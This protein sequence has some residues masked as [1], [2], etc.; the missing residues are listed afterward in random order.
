MRSYKE[1]ERSPNGVVHQHTLHRIDCDLCDDFVERKHFPQRPSPIGRTD[2]GYWV[3]EGLYFAGTAGDESEPF[4]LAGWATFHVVIKSA[5]MRSE[6]E[7]YGPDCV[8]EILDI[9]PRHVGDVRGM[10]KQLKS[11]KA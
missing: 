11:R 2:V 1:N 10:L 4:A 3:P 5:F 6:I 7:G 8:E 9:C